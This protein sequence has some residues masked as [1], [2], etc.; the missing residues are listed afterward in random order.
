MNQ[1]RILAPATDIVDNGDSYIIYMDLPGIPKNEVRIEIADDKLGISGTRRPLYQS[2]SQYAEL[3]FGDFCR[4][5]SL[6]GEIDTDN[7]KAEMTNGVLKITMPK[8]R[9]VTGR[10]IE[11]ADAS[12]AIEA[13][14]PAP[15]PAAN[16]V[17]DPFYSCEDGR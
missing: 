3:K 13:P 14:A 9:L 5:V 15:A 11:I 17:D 8:I 7:I 12:A 10:R 16:H 1:S 4:I 6:N 2:K